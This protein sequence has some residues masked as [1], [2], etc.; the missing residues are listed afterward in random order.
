MILT[1]E[2]QQ[3]KNAA[4][5]EPGRGMLNCVHIKKGYIEATDG[6]I[7]ARQKIDYQGD[8]EIL[9]DAKE[10]G[11]CKNSDFSKLD[12]KVGQYPDTDSI[13]PK[14]NPILEVELDKSLLTRLLK[15]MP[16]ESFLFSFYP[17]IGVLPIRVENEKGVGLIMPTIKKN[18]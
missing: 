15:S 2:Q 12:K 1:K 16:G 18:L 13:F 17:S 7:F 8:E 6:Y 5:K 3:I 10:L 4:A 11:K 9:V 14:E